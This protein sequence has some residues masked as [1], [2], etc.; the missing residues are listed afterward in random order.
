MIV[1]LH[2]FGDSCLSEQM[3]KIDM[4]IHN[5]LEALEVQSDA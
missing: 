2:L 5:Y 1:F 4:T 3:V